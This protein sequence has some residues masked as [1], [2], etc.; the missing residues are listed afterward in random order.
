MGVDLAKE[1]DRSAVREVLGAILKPWTTAHT[2]DEIRDIF[3]R[4]D[5]SWGPYWTFVELVE[6]DDRCSTA[7][8][9]F[10]QVEQPGIGTYLMPGSPLSFDTSE[11]LPARRAPILGEHTDEVLTDMLGMSDAEIGRLYADGV[12]DG[13][14]DG[15]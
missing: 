9:M 11:R 14:A 6:H 3:D 2:L 7:N 15:A 1:G 5:V 13:S 4:H 8:P 12:V 10:E